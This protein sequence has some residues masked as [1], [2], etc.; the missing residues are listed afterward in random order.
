MA[1]ATAVRGARRPAQGITWTR[2]DG[3]A[4]DLTGATLTGLLR[5]RASG[6]T[7]AIAGALTVTDPTAGVFRWDYAA[8]DVAE[9]GAFD[10]QFDAAFDV[11]ATPARTFVARWDV[12]G[13]LG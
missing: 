12:R 6:Q 10:V 8:A 11:G 9:A 1:L 3:N 2:E 7:R 4:E 13:S 5:N